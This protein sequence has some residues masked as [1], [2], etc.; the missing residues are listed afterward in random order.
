MVGVVEPTEDSEFIP[1]EV[2]RAK[3]Y[4][5]LQP[6]PLDAKLVPSGDFMDAR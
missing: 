3:A 4:L 2:V 6:L 5:W 1:G